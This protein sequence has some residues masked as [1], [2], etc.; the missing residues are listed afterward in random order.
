MNMESVFIY[1]SSVSF[2]SK[3]LKQFC[4]F[5]HIDLAHILLNLCACFVRFIHKY[6][7]FEGT[8]VNVNSF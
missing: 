3:E 5:P 1:L 4:S 2:I 8:K 6:F 7:N